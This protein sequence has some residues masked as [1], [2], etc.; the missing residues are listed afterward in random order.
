MDGFGLRTCLRYSSCFILSSDALSWLLSIELSYNLW[1]AF[2]TPT[3]PSFRFDPRFELIFVVDFAFDNPD[4][5][6]LDELD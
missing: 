2:C 4:L 1:I 3:L 6:F 5:R